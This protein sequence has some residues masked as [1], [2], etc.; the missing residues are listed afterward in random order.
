MSTVPII[1]TTTISN[2][3]L[4]LAASDLELPDLPSPLSLTQSHSSSNL[5][6]LCVPGQGLSLSAPGSPRERKLSLPSTLHQRRP[7]LSGYAAAAEHARESAR[8]RKLS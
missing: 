5:H 6:C 3:S 7:S 1:T 2:G 8:L 4:S